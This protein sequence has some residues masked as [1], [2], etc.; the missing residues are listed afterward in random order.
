MI[1]VTRIGNREYALVKPAL[2]C[3]TFIAT[4][5]QDSLSLGIE[6]IVK[7]NDPSHYQ[8]MYLKTYYVNSIL[9][10]E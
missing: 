6:S 1:V 9:G 4:N 8:I 5:Q 7:K 2:I 10:D 3:P